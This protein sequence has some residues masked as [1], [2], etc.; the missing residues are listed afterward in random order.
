MV[1]SPKPGK[2]KFLFC[3]MLLQVP[4]FN[5]YMEFRSLEFLVLKTTS[6]YTLLLLSAHT[7][8]AASYMQSLNFIS[9]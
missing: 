7:V 8:Y 4:S 2:A 1:L 5:G 3:Q 6:S 9:G